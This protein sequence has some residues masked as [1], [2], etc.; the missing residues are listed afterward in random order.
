[1]LVPNAICPQ[2][3]IHPISAAALWRFAVSECYNRDLARKIPA[4]LKAHRRACPSDTIGQSNARMECNESNLNALISAN[5]RQDL[6]P[7]DRLSP[8]L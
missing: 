2:W 1:M 3:G 7:P 8:W 6:M 5:Q 4:V